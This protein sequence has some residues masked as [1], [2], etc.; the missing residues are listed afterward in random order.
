M[1]TI[2]EEDFKRNPFV[3]LLI[4]SYSLVLI[5]KIKFCYENSHLIEAN[6]SIAPYLSKIKENTILKLS[7]ITSM[8]DY[9]N[10]CL[11][12]H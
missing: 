5:H 2:D 11:E 7:F 12:F 6:Y 10:C 8:L 1:K 9:L 3:C 4:R